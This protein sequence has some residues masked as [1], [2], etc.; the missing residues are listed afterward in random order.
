MYMG[1]IILEGDQRC[2]CSQGTRATDVSTILC[3]AWAIWSER[4][5]RNHGEKERKVAQSVKWS[6]D[7]AWDLSATGRERNDLKVAVKHHWKPPDANT[8][9]INVDAAFS[10]GNHHGEMDHNVGGS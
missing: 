5:A 7:V 9:K 3:C 4:N 10:E 1:K 8:I 6:L 2:C